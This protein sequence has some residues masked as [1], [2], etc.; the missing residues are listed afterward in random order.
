MDQ[1]ESTA[2]NHFGRSQMA[3]RRRWLQFSLATL[4]A[5]TS[6]IALAVHWFAERR[7]LQTAE[8]DYESAKSYWEAGIGTVDHLLTA[9]ERLYSAELANSFSS[10][11]AAKINYLNRTARLERHI[12]GIVCLMDESDIRRYRRAGTQLRI[13]R[14]KLEG[15]LDVKA[16]DQEWLKATHGQQDSSHGVATH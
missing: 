8:H 10:R 2:A 14:E 6:V 9:S 13:V 16:Q 3:T 1:S 11:R 4:L 15:E 7:R 12:V 5:S